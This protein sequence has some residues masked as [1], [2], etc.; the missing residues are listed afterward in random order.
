MIVDTATITRRQNRVAVSK[1]A[2]LV[3]R[4]PHTR[5]F[6]KYILRNP[7]QEQVGLAE[8]WRLCIHTA[9]MFNG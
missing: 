1:T 8:A 7:F 6:P 4:A 5:K 9:L 2:T 3:A